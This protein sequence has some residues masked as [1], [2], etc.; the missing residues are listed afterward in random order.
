MPVP[1][2]LLYRLTDRDRH[3]PG[4]GFISREIRKQENS[5][6]IFTEFSDFAGL[7]PAGYVMNITLLSGVAQ[8]DPTRTVQALGVNLI[9]QAENNLGNLFP[10]PVKKFGI[11]EV[12]GDTITEVVHPD[13]VLIDEEIG[14]RVLGVFSGAL[15]NTVIVRFSGYIIP[16]GNFQRF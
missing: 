5:N 11:A 2:E 13:I 7:I 15:V 4:W 16:R 3:L 12:V 8:P 9:D 1:V 10:D 14:L 6:N